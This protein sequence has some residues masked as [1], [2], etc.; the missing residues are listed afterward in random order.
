MMTG[1]TQIDTIIISAIVALATSLLLLYL[2]EIYIENKKFQR[3]K[4]KNLFF[5]T[6]TKYEDDLPINVMFDPRS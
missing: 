6:M 2:R 5:A 3:T 1:D 4:I